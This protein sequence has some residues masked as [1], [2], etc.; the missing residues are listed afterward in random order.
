M[1]RID[2]AVGDNFIMAAY[3]ERLI[4]PGKQ[5]YRPIVMPQSQMLL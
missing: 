4:G 5:P 2:Q 1:V 3:R